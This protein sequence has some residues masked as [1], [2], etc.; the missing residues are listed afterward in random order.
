MS[1]HHESNLLWIWKGAQ[2]MNCSSG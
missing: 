1:H 2:H